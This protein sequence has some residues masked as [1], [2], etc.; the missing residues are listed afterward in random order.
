MPHFEVDV[1]LNQGLDESTRRFLQSVQASANRVIRFDGDD[2]SVRLTVDVAGM[3]RDEAIRAAA[4]RRTVTLRFES[5]DFVTP[6]E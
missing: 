6:G 5:P 3:T 4:H 1:L 2:R